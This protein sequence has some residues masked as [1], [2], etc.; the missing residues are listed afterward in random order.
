MSDID[1]SPHWRVED[2]RRIQSSLCQHLTQ[3][4]LLESGDWGFELSDISI[5]TF[6]WHG[7][8]DQD[9]PVDVGRYVAD[10]IAGCTAT[11]I[12]GEN[13]TLLRRH[14]KPIMERLVGAVR[15]I[16]AEGPDARL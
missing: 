4:G 6:L 11:F 1:A 13:H 2:C 3:D 7:E 8:A 5:P 12:P 15:A 9:V 14:W 16:T 10:G